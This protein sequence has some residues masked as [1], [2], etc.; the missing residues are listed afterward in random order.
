M[1]TAVFILLLVCLAVA[2][3]QVLYSGYAYPGY[4]SYGTYGHVAAPV[5]TYGYPAYGGAYVYKK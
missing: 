5:Y 4:A 1:K 3:A 2:S